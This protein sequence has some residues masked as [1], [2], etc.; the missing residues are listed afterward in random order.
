M[1]KMKKILK[2]W[3]GTEYPICHGYLLVK[4]CGTPASVHT[5]HK[6]TTIVIWILNVLN[7]FQFDLFKFDFDMFIYVYKN[8]II[9][10]AKFLEITYN[11][12]SKSSY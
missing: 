4:R 7:D 8:V 3:A 6:L 1:K 9:W 5:F 12:V 11:A 10:L 2:K